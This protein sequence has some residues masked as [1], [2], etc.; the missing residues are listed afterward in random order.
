MK[1]RRGRGGM[2]VWGDGRAGRWKWRKED[3]GKEKVEKWVEEFFGVEY[4][5]EKE[6][7][8]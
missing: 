3:K 6:A 4:E 5:K 8:E 2:V 7:A 1:E